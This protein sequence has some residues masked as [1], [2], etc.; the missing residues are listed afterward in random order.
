MG[1]GLAPLYFD[2]GAAVAKTVRAHPGGGGRRCVVIWI[3]WQRDEGD[4][5]AEWA[6]VIAEIDCAGCKAVSSTGLE[7]TEGGGRGAAADAVIKGAVQIDLSGEVRSVVLRGYPGKLSVVGANFVDPHDGRRGGRARVARE[8]NAVNCDLGRCLAGGVL[9]VDT[10]GV[11]VSGIKGGKGVA[12]SRFWKND[13]RADIVSAPEVI[14]KIAGVR[15]SWV[16]GEGD[17]VSGCRRHAKVCGCRWPAC[18]GG[19]GAADHSENY[20]VGGE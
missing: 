13:G 18:R 19:G 5:I 7:E 14:V 20:R 2:L 6:D 17:G 11:G 9:G 3:R 1:R 15:R 4:G 16:P 8:A 10:E 12:G